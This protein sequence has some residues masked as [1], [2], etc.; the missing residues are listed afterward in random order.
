MLQSDVEKLLECEDSLRRIESK[1]R[2][3]SEGGIDKEIFEKSKR[4]YYKKELFRKLKEEIYYSGHILKDV[5][6]K[7]NRLGLQ[8]L[9]E[10]AENLKGWATTLLSFLSLCKEEVDGFIKCQEIPAKSFYL[11]F[12]KRI[13]EKIGG[14]GFLTEQDE[15]ATPILVAD[16]FTNCLH[17][18]ALKLS[19]LAKKPEELKETLC[20][21]EIKDLPDEM[22]ELVISFCKAFTEGV[23][24]NKSVYHPSDEGK[25]FAVVDRNKIH[26][27]I[28]GVGV[29]HTKIDLREGEIVYHDHHSERVNILKNVLESFEDFYCRE[30][31]DEIGYVLTC[32]FERRPEN[33][34]RIGK[35][36]SVMPS[37]DLYWDEFK[38]DVKSRIEKEIEDAKWCIVDSIVHDV[39]SGEIPDY[40]RVRDCMPV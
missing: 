1:L 22:K 39:E 32:R 12:Q 13:S 38:E 11:K 4:G 19:Q 8:N 21:G 3:F 5:C 24:F 10:V 35:V 29:H 30:G 36:L 31:T 20:S 7:L 37:L 27:S 25:Q 18:F 15:T 14:C 23:E 2:G 9:T 28:G 16:S 40:Y 17:E 33:L 26:V 34:K 6:N